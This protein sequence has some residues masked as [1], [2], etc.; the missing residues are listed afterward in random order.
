MTNSRA[1][2]HQSVGILCFLFVWYIYG[3]WAD[4]TADIILKSFAL[5]PTIEAFWRLINNGMLLEAMASSSYR[6]GWGIFYA[7]L[8]GLPVGV[9]LGLSE[10][11]QQTLLVPIQFF[12]MTSPLS[13]MPIVVMVI[14]GWDSGIIF[15]LAFA[16]VWAII[17][18]TSTAVSRID[19]GWLKVAN[20]YQ[21]SLWQKIRIVVLPAIAS[22]VFTGIRLSVG[23]CWVVLVPAEFLGVTSGLGYAINDAR[24]TLDYSSMM[25]LVLVIG[26]LGYLLDTT[27]R[28]II[29]RYKWER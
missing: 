20:N 15:L 18:S 25:A 10:R 7:V 24:D 27:L 29:S 9:L 26:A 5:L 3:L 17:L 23:V 12:R 19:T 13:L 4:H 8:I 2:L 21:I 22:D 11:V 1:F 16:G 14:P 28:T 6:I